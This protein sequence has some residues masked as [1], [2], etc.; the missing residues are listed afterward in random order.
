[1]ILHE[2]KYVA[3]TRTRL[4][5]RFFFALSLRRLSVESLKAALDIQREKISMG[6]DRIF[7]SSHVQFALRLAH[8]VASSFH[9]STLG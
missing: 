1:M 5:S 4:N 6:N 3:I 9:Q 2:N 8:I 7:S